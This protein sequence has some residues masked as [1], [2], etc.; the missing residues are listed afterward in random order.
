MVDDRV[1]G[2]LTTE[3]VVL[4]GD[5]IVAKQARSLLN[6]ALAAAKATGALVRVDVAPGHPADALF[7][8]GAGVDLLIIGSG[9]SGPVGRISL[10]KT[11]S[12]LVEGASFPVLVVPRAS[13]AAAI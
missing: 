5:A 8:L 13:D 4:A 10:G 1:A 6:R 3:E 12:P 9:R 7:A 2:G 11:G